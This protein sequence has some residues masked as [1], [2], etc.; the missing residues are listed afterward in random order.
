VFIHDSNPIRKAHN[1][2]QL[3]I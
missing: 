3:W 1:P 2:S